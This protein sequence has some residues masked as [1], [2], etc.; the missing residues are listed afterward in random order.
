M[1]T[2]LT[3]KVGR[4]SDTLARQVTGQTL[5][6]AGGREGRWLGQPDEVDPG[7]A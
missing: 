2:D 7:I 4:A 3:G 6:V 1:N 5:V